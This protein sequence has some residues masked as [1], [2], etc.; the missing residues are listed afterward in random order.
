MQL[1]IKVACIWFL[2][3]LWDNP[4]KLVGLSV[5]KVLQCRYRI[6]CKSWTALYKVSMVGCYLSVCLPYPSADVYE[7]LKDCLFR[8]EAV[9]GRFWPLFCSCWQPI[10]KYFEVLFIGCWGGGWDWQVFDPVSKDT[11]IYTFWKQGS[12]LVNYCFVL[13]TCLVHW[14]AS[15]LA[16]STWSTWRV[17]IAPPVQLVWLQE[18]VHNLFDAFSFISCWQP[19]GS[20]WCVRR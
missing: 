12:L 9:S 1:P 15:V 16:P 13:S 17:V 3:H 20:E 11:W 19:W 6:H 10:V 7:Y 5:R 8:D 14:L 18:K 2:V 4:W